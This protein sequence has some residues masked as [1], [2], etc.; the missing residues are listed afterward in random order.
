MIKD[1]VIH[2]GDT[3]TGSTSIQKVLIDRSWTAEGIEVCY[4]TAENHVPLARS[5]SPRFPEVMKTSRQKFEFVRRKFMQS[6]ADIGL[7]SAETFEFVE[8]EALIEAIDTYLPEFRANL[9]LIA[10]IRPHHERL[11]SSFSERSKSF[12]GTGNLDEVFASFQ[13]TGNM[14]YAPRL[15]KWRA[16]FGE[17]YEIRPMVRA[18]LKEGDVVADFFEF[19]FQGAPVTLPDTRIA[20]T[21]LTLEDVVV[22]REMQLM[23]HEQGK[24]PWEMIDAQL[25][26]GWN[27]AQILGQN[28]MGPGTRIQL[29]RTLAEQVTEAYRE[30]A[31]IVDEKYMNGTPLSDA[32]GQAMQKCIETPQSLRIEDHFAEVSVG[33]IRAFGRLLQRMLLSDPLNFNLMVRDPQI[34]ERN[35]I[36]RGKPVEIGLHKPV[37]A[38]GKGKGKGR[39]QGKGL[40]KGR[41]PGK[42]LGKGKGGPNRA[43]AARPDLA[44]D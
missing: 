40:G 33:H 42:G 26:L 28:R 25:A 41:G 17:A 39:G 27:F 9:R 12:P 20:N 8:P 44:A 34:K 5:L 23:I 21:S 31:A 32:L 1:L 22:M 38:G 10:Y 4:P 36:L 18:H 14:D 13:K 19:L 15:A 6:D 37:I 11:V 3:K 35:A 2:V 24:R 16:A 30:D 29:H 43:D 7:I